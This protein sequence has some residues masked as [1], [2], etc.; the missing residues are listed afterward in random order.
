MIKRAILTPVKP[1]DFNAASN[2]TADLSN[3]NPRE[4]FDPVIS[5]L[6]KM[7]IGKYFWF[8]ANTVKGATEQAGGMVEDIIGVPINEFEHQPPVKLFAQ[9]HPEDIPQMFAFTNYWIGYVNKLGRNEKS[10]V[11]PTIYMRLKNGAGLYKWTMVQ[12]IDHVLDAN[13]N[14]L[15]G[16]TVVTDISHVKTEG[17]PMMSILNMQD[18]TC[19][20]FF[21]YNENGQVISQGELPKLSTREIEVLQYISIGNSSKQIADEL[22]ISV[23]TVDNHRQSMLKKTNTKSTAELISFA[24]RNGFL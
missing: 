16:L 5:Q 20:H 18:E 11:H 7:A 24:I 1:E 23:K 13:G 4:A 2:P 6:H 12:Y 14:I 8:I 10:L 17:P 22:A 15:Y 19:L 9:S 3:I 21:C